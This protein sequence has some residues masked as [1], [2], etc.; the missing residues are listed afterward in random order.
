[1]YK[2]G[3]KELVDIFFHVGDDNKISPLQ[4]DGGVVEPGHVGGKGGD[5]TA[6]AATTQGRGAIR[7]VELHANIKDRTKIGNA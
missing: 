7:E 3:I 5:V 4:S 1:M 6:V 2:G